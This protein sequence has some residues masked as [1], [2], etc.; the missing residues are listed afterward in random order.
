MWFKLQEYSVGPHSLNVTFTG[1]LV[2]KLFQQLPHDIKA[3]RSCDFVLVVFIESIGRV[4]RQQSRGVRWQALDNVVYAD[5]CG[6]LES[7]FKTV[8]EG[9]FLSMMTIFIP[10]A[11]V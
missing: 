5:H 8:V 4:N 6:G 7:T 2:N 10:Q 1:F 9:A 11:F 3:N